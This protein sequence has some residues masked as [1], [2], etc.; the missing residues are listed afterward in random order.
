MPDN[1][2]LI[3]SFPFIPFKNIKKKIWM[4]GSSGKMPA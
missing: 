1:G 3:T 2:I 4:P